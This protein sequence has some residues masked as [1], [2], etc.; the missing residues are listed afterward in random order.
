MCADLLRDFSRKLAIILPH[1][2]AHDWF[3]LAFVTVKLIG[4][5]QPIPIHKNITFNNNGMGKEATAHGDFGWI[6][7][8]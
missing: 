6:K 7:N 4:P 2:S 5:A 8:A 1:I 3:S